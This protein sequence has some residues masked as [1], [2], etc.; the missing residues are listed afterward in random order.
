MRSILGADERQLTLIEEWITNGVSLDFTSL[1]DSVDFENTHMVI[2]HAAEV[3]QRLQEYIQLRAITPLPA[4]HPCPFG[5]QP[6]HVIIK[7]NKKPR[8]V[9]DLSRNLNKNLQYEYFHYANLTE[10]TD[11][12]KPGSWFVKL[13][14]SNCYLSFPLHSATF[15]H[16]IFRFEGHLYQFVR[17]PF[18]LSSAPRICTMLLSVLHH[19]IV[20]E[21]SSL[22]TAL[23]R[24]LDDL[25]FI[26]PSQSA[27]QFVLETAQ[28]VIR[29]FGLVVN[30]DKTEGPAQVISFLGVQLDSI[31]CTL[32][33]T[34][35]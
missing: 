24:Y 35:E 27:A 13:D 25:L 4:D 9:I 15:P 12:A 5:V 31:R 8:L 26:T 16:F 19:R 23:I 20:A 33:C 18:G 29:A 6:L 30:R 32:S 1:P 28:R 17:M 14:L 34:S 2:D 21:C 11:A 22:L 3:R 10:A 7:E